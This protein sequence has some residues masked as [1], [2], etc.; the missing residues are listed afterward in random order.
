MGEEG[1]DALGMVSVGGEGGAVLK[2][3][4]GERAG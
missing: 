4:L 1:I 2:G 3:A